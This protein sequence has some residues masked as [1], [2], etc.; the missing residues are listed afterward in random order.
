MALIVLVAVAVALGFFYLQAPPATP[1][2]AGD[3]A[4]DIELRSAGGSMT[5]QS[6]RGFPVLMVLFD[7]QWPLSKAYLP[8]IERLH[9]HYGP[10]GLSV[11]GIGFDKDPATLRGF[12]KDADIT[13]LVFEDPGGRST[14]PVYGVPT[15]QTPWVYLLSPGGRVEAVYSDVRRWREGGVREKLKALL[16]KET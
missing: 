12:V 15:K 3:M 16:P 4:P 2:K 9:R 13:F 1:I 8:E 14:G 6:L 11:I 5:L 7:T 10:I